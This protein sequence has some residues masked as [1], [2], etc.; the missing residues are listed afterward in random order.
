MVRC[1]EYFGVT[2][3]GRTSSEHRRDAQRSDSAGS[4]RKRE[5]SERFRGVQERS[6]PRAEP[7]APR[8]VALFVSCIA[9]L[10]APGPA[11]A[12]VEV[13]E[14]MGCR[15][16]VPDAQTCCGQAALNSGYVE[17]ASRLMRHWIE[18]FEPYDAVVSASGSCTA[19]V[20]HQ[21]PRV[22]PGPWSTRA[23]ELTDR[24]YELSQFVA[25]YGKDLELKLDATVSFH[26]SCHMLRSLGERDAPREVLSRVE[27]LKLIELANPDT[28]CGFGGT[29]STKFPEVS[30]SMGDQKLADA[31][32]TGTQA[33][34]SA[35]P[36]CLI[37]L[38]ARAAATGRGV[39]AYHI[40]ELIRDACR[41]CGARGSASE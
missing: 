17:E 18:V 19:T 34:V 1:A 14:A 20:H 3:R 22:L 24:T 15:V 40:A 28:C 4:P 16:E 12:T 13:L 30:V 6:E 2:P 26:D 32:A 29:F 23:G 31:T 36:G 38:A 27:G 35:D 7:T 5:R 8:T 9:D 39:R 21:Y 10:A 33:L 11:R 37:H 41:S 25:T